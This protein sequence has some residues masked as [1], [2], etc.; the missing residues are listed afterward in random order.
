[1]K[2]DRGE[3]GECWPWKGRLHK[4]AGVGLFEAEANRTTTAHRFA[5]RVTHALTVEEMEERPVRHT[6]GVKSCCNPA[7]LE[8]GELRE[9]W[10]QG[11]LS[12]GQVQLIRAMA[13]A[14]R[15]QKDIATDPQFGGIS[16]PMVSTIVGRRTYQDVP[17]VEMRIRPR[18]QDRPRALLV[19]P[20]ASREEMMAAELAAVAE[21][22]GIELQLEDEGW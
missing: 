11:K 5:Y 16:A 3:K 19:E 2:V 20:Q 10:Y 21:G 15:L 9:H 14:G 1:M 4:T 22:E 12:D 18:T 7:H 8:M 6:C 13:K 17:E